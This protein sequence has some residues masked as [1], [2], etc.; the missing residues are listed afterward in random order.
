MFDP[1]QG[2]NDLLARY[3]DACPTP[4]PSANFMPGVWRKIEA[5][6][7]FLYQLQAYSRRMAATAAALS[8]LL[9]VLHFAPMQASRE[10]YNMTYMDT[11]E[12][13]STTELMAYAPSSS[14]DGA[15]EDLQ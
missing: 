1:F 2:L 9:I 5:R 4:E 11:L 12:E 6:R 7:G 8:L 10:V 13:D 3:A 14:A 15:P